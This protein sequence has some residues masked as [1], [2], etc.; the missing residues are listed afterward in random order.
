MVASVA[1]YRVIVKP[2]C[3]LTRS[4]RISVVLLL[5]VVPLCVAIE[6]GLAGL[7]PVFV[8]AGL[9]LSALAYAF[10]HIGCHAEDY[11][12]IS[13]EGDRLVVEKRNYKDTSQMVFQRYW[14]HVVVRDTLRGEQRLW[15]RSHGKEVEVG[16]YL[17]NQ[18]RTALARQLQK[19]TGA[20]LSL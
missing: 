8:F 13:I 11:E 17:N 10:Y 12:S 19:R 20:T 2:N 5:A 7:W 16:H 4:G 6:F 15:L 14:A 3:S 1:D 9:E 18:Q